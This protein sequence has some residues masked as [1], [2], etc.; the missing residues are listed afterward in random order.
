MAWTYSGDPSASLRD[1]VRFL[2]GDT[3]TSDQ[4]LSDAEVDYTLTSASDDASL[5][6]VKCA[7]ALAA[8]YARRAD[9]TVGDLSLSY[10]QLSKHYLDLV[11]QLQ[12]TAAV[13]LAAPYAGGISVSDK[14]TDEDDS[15]RVQPAF[16]V[17][18]HSYDT[19]TDDT[20]A[21]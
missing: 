8:H 2:I 16:R 10:S 14:E 13:A 4:Q 20:K 19:G 17:G 7:Q 15:D 9:K 18:L 3:D 21:E 12:A 6:A 11:A 5:A 1:E